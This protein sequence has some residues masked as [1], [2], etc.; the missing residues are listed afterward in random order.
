MKNVISILIDSVFSECIGTGRTKES[1]TPFIDKMIKDGIFVPNVYSY[2]PYTDAATKG[3]Y[4]GRPS[5]RDYG[6][7]F[8]LN[9]S[10]YYHFRTFS[11]AGYETYAFYYPYY[12][13]GSKVRQYIDHTVFT[14]GVDFS[15]IWLGKYGYYAE[16]KK[17]IGLSEIEEQLLIQYTDLLFDC[18]LYFYRQI[19]DNQ[20]AS[21]I[22]KE[23]E[24]K[25]KTGYSLLVNEFEKYT[26][27]KEEYINQL[28]DDNNHPLTHLNDYDYD[29]A[30]DTKWIKENI[31]KRYKGFF[32][33]LDKK[34]LLLN[35]QNNK[36]SI[37]NCL[38]NGRY[39]R[40]SVLC[41]FAGRYYRYVSRKPGWQIVASFQKKIDVLI[42]ALE[43]REETGKPFYV[44][45]HTEEPHNYVAFFSYDCKD[46]S[47]IREEIDYLRPLLQGC[48]KE[49]KGNLTYQLSLRYVDLCIK[50]LVNSLEERGL[51]DDTT[52]VLMADHGTSYS[53]NPI[54]DSV[55]NNFYKENYKTPLLIWNSN[56]LKS[57]EIKYGGLFS[58]EDVQPS[59]CDSVGIKIPEEYHGIIIMDNPEGRECV[60]TE[61]MG[62]GCPDMLSRDVWMTGRNKKYSIAYKNKIKK[63]FDFLHPVELYNL[64]SDPLEMHNICQQYAEIHDE[65]LAILTTSIKQRF[66]EIQ[67]ETEEFIDNIFN[68]KSIL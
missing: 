40:N 56:S 52:I 38:K 50:R 30:I 22:I 3:L 32:R 53:Y 65:K 20:E 54:R 44:S 6:Y 27:N 16:K 1:S 37:S 48:G 25:I 60:V 43:D 11:E 21:L 36:I 42:K 68:W 26:R 5:L 39:L 28:L 7:Y 29:R 61:Y 33:E 13:I 12:L 2:G 41:L 9:S 46:Q 67:K 66:A 49:F 15:A 59:I 62:P 8:G 24:P 63:H 34:E 51:L 10:N 19:D 18:W 17:T 14:S 57:K 64:E 35:L 45:L 47:L 58:A 55:V 31:Y 4:S 23:I